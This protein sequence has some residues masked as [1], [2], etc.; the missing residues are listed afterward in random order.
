M[1]PHI[2]HWVISLKIYL[3][4]AERPLE[5]ELYDPHL[6]SILSSLHNVRNF[7]LSGGPV[8]TSWDDFPPSFQNSLIQFWMSRPLESFTLDGIN[9]EHEIAPPTLRGNAWSSLRHLALLW[10]DLDA[11]WN[12]TEGS[13]IPLQSLTLGGLKVVRHLTNALQRNGP[14]IDVRQLREL[15]AILD[16]D[17]DFALFNRFLY[18][19]SDTL[20]E[21]CLDVTLSGSYF[22]LS[23]T[24]LKT[25]LLPA[26]GQ[27]NPSPQFRSVILDMS[28]LT[29]LQSVYLILDAHGTGFIP[30]GDMSSTIQTIRILVIIDTTSNV[31]HS[32][33]ADLDTWLGGQLQNLSA[34]TSVTIEIHHSGTNDCA[35][36]NC[37]CV[38]NTAVSDEEVCAAAR[39]EMPLLSERGILS[40]RF[41]I[42]K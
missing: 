1:S 18:S 41:N 38:V 29:R 12:L 40:I 26:P 20:E 30:W 15:N 34:L 21:L 24:Q 5:T 10:T 39:R 7:L 8:V 36:C 11:F 22:F 28:R 3:P 9:A 23:C 27:G 31:P 2:A 25:N 17:E 6:P 19:L 4:C 33:W 14:T 32:P 35:L 37:T 16:D 42:S 13:V